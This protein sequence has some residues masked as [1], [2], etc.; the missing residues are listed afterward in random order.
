ML[1]GTE[2]KTPWN[3]TL[4]RP[5]SF[6]ILESVGC[7]FTSLTAFRGML[8]GKSLL[9]VGVVAPDALAVECAGACDSPSTVELNGDAVAD[10]PEG[11]G[12]VVA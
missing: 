11:A 6:I 2:F 4:R 5:M 9:S 1:L 3:N 12:G 10:G 7:A 8:M